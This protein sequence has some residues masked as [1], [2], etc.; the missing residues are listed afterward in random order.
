MVATLETPSPGTLTTVLGRP[1]LIE[2]ITAFNPTASP[3][4]L[5]EFDDGALALYLEH[6]HAKLSEPDS[7]K[8]WSRPGDTAAIVWRE[9]HDAA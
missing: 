6:L 5:C 3:E 8:T 4:F 9:A 7:K 2:R 1:Q